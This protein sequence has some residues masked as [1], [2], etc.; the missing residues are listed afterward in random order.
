[1]PALDSERG[2]QHHFGDGLGAAR[3]HLAEHHP[4]IRRRQRHPHRRQDLAGLEAGAPVAE[5]EVVNRH[6]PHPAQLRAQ[7]HHG[8]E[9]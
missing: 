3:P 4:L 6:L 1:M 2:G 8:V 5:E 9:S 7:D